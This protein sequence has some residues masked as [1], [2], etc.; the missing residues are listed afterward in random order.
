MGNLIV[1]IINYHTIQIL[2]KKCRQ[3][4]R[5]EAFRVKL[6]LRSLLLSFSFFQSVRGVQRV[7]GQ[8]VSSGLNS[9]N[10]TFNGK[11]MNLC[12]LSVLCG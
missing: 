9:L 1:Y 8:D 12:D 4:S 10:I 7:R 5:T 11:F 6:K 3:K 2:S